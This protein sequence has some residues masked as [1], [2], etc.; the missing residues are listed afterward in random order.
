MNRREFTQALFGSGVAAVAPL[1][2]LGKAAVPVARSRYI[3]A[4]ALAHARTGISVDMIADQVGVRNHTARRLFAQ[5]IRRGVVETPNATGMAR[6]SAPL[7]RITSQEMVMGPGGTAVVRGS[8]QDTLVRA[9]DQSNTS[10][11]RRALPVEDNPEDSAQ[12]VDEVPA[13]DLSLSNDD[14][15]P[16][17]ALVAERSAE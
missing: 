15:E 6:L 3:F 9:L 17:E 14:S 11:Q 2:A 4:V 12:D 13:E 16:P 8:V 1:P 7:L 10:Q 5:L